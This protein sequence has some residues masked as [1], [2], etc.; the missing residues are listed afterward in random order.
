M[1][2]LSKHGRTW[3][4]RKPA[5]TP[6]GNY[7]VAYPV[8]AWGVM[9]AASYLT[10]MIPN[11]AAGRIVQHTTGGY[12]FQPIKIFESDNRPARAVAAAP[13][14]QSVAARALSSV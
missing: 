4:A 3:P 13:P 11:G 12:C 2:L 10:L 14:R 5:L 1:I 6:D 8:G 9:H 7:A